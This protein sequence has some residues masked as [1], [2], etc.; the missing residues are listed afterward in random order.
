[1]NLEAKQV[2]IAKFNLLND[3]KNWKTLA[4]FCLKEA[5]NDRTN[6]KKLY[7][8]LIKYYSKDYIVSQSF[9]GDL[10]R[11][12]SKKQSKSKIINQLV[13]SRMLWM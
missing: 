6:G 2:L 8:N 3:K 7:R 13:E 5:D 10:H 11:K 9:L 4:Y 1:M 12:I